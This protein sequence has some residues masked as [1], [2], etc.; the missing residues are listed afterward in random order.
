MRALTT[1][2]ERLAE[3]LGGTIRSIN[4]ATDHL[5]ATIEAENARVG[6][7]CGRGYQRN[8]CQ[9]S[10][11][12]DDV[13]VECKRSTC[14]VDTGLPSDVKETVAYIVEALNEANIPTDGVN[15]RWSVIEV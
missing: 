3:L 6:I 13:R 8:W 12:V 7:V 1:R 2:V 10:I 9:V 4:V 5:T 14:W 15:P 11:R